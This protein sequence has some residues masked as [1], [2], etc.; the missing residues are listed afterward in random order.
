MTDHNELRTLALAATPGPLEY[1]TA[2]AQRGGAGAGACCHALATAAT[3][4]QP[5]RTDGYEIDM[6]KGERDAG[7]D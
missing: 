5:R 3:G 4:T 1:A 2:G 7:T 6:T